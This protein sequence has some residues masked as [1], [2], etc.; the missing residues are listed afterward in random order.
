MAWAHANDVPVTPAG[1]RTGL[2]G[3]A[4]PVEGGISLS[5]R[6]L[7]RIVTIDE[8]NHQVSG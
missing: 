8:R 6:R 1:A 2:S 7:N 5:T 4:L 3:G